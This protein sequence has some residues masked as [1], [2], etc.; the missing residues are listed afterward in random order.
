MEKQLTTDFQ[1]VML[2]NKTLNKLPGFLKYSSPAFFAQIDYF[3]NSTVIIKAVY[4][5]REGAEIVDVH[6]EFRLNVEDV[7]ILKIEA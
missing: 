3:D 4:L 2:S 6:N 7:T 1:K 5:E